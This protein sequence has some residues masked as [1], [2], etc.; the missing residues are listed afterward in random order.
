MLTIQTGGTLTNVLRGGRQS[1][2]RAGHGDGDRRGLHVDEY[3]KR[4]GRRPGHGHAYHP[5]RRHGEQCGGGSVGQSAGSNGTV[6]VTG[7]GSSW[8]NGPSGGLNIGSFGTGT[9]T[10]ANGGMVIN[11]TAFT[12]NIGNGAG[13]QGTVTVTG[14]G[15]TWSNSSGVNIGNLGTGTLTIADGGTVTSGPVMIATSAGVDWNTQHRRGRGQSGGCTRHAHC[16]ER[17]IW[18]WHRYAQL[19]SHVHR[20]CV[21]ARDQRQWLR[22]RARGHHHPHGQQH[23]YRRHRRQWRRVDRGRLDR[24]IEPDDGEQRR[25]TPWQRH[26]GLDRQSTPAASSFRV[27][28]ERPAR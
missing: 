25:R 17:R 27:R 6:T 16:A 21:C 18:R 14:A 5:K 7:P 2:G 23:L 28:W 11:I 12:A 22:Q 13:S 9:L 10:I 15:S 4:R 8:I 20:L 19:Q 1:T 26:R 24:V 3:R